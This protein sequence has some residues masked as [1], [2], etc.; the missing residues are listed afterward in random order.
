MPL[1]LLPYRNGAFVQYGPDIR[2]Y[3]DTNADGRADRHDVILTGFGTEDS[4]LFPHQFLRQPGGQ[5]FVAQGRAPVKAMLDAAIVTGN[6][7]EVA[8]VAKYARAA[9]PE[10]SEAINLLIDDWH[11]VVAT[12]KVAADSTA[13]DIWKGKVELGGF[14]TSG[15]TS[16]VGASTAIDVVRETKRWRHK[17]HLAAMVTDTA[18]HALQLLG[19][20]NVQ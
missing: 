10:A 13:S 20:P 3:R 6:E 16:D 4:H 9:A 17:L 14:A 19:L 12:K 5:I 18:Q 2:F 1:G 15:N 11:K 8:T 7:A